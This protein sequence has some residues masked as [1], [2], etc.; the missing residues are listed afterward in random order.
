MSSAWVFPGSFR[1]VESAKWK[2]GPVSCGLAISSPESPKE[3]MTA[4]DPETAFPENPAPVLVARGGLVESEH[5]EAWVLT[6]RA[7]SVEA[8]GGAYDEPFYARSTI[9]A[10]QVLPLIETGAAEEFGVS[11][12]EL[13]C[14][15]HNAEGIR[16]RPVAALLERLGFSS[17]DL[18]CGTQEPGD[19]KRRSAMRATGEAPSALHNNCSG[20][21]AGFLALAKH[22]GV[23]AEEYLD[24]MSASQSLVRESIASMCDLDGADLLAAVDGCSAPTYRLPLRSLAMSFARVANPEGLKAEREGAY[25]RILDAVAANPALI[26]GEHKRICTA[27]S[28]VSGGRLFP[29]IGAEGVYVVGERGT[30]RALAVKLDDGGLRGLHPLVM[31]LLTRHGFLSEDETL[32]LTK[33]RSKTLRNWSGKEVGAI[34]VVA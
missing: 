11:D 27:L 17:A 26:A 20:K 18:Q 24:P 29:K 22:L 12:V 7:G 28:R 33:W 4:H 21:H 23:P 6:D 1:Q 13:T 31:E 10:L 15:S 2:R 14:A 16:T 8:G 25:E 34:E 3:P 19:A 30:N 32:T 5:R 9:K